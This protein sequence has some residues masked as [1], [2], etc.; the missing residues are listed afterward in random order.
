MCYLL[1]SFQTF[2]ICIPRFEAPT[3][4]EELPT[5]VLPILEGEAAEPSSLA[6]T[7]SLS[8]LSTS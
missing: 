2:Y 7:G 3:G 5:E 1:P 8:S 4:T 6:K